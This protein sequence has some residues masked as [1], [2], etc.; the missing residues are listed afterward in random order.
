VSEA[1]QTP[2][3]LRA[4]GL[5]LGFALGAVAAAPTAAAAQGTL[6]VDS[7]ADSAKLGGSGVNCRSEAAGNPCTLRAAIETVNGF[8]P[9]G[10]TI[11][12]PAAYSGA[13]AIKLTLGQLDLTRS[14][15]IESTGGPGS[16]TLEAQGASRVMQVAQGASVTL[17]GL[18]IGHGNP[19]G[20]GGG[21]RNL[22]SL[23]LDGVL[24][25][26][27]QVSGFRGGG[28][29]TT[30][31]LTMKGG[32]VSGNQALASPGGGLGGG[33]YVFDGGSLTAAGTSFT[34]NTAGAVGGGIRDRGAADLDGVT[35]SGNSA[36]AGGGIAVRGPGSLQLKK[37]TVSRNA[38]A[39]A[40]RTGGGGGLLAEAGTNLTMIDGLLAG[41]SVGSGVGG[42]MLVLDGT[43]ALTNDTFS[44]NSA[45]VGGA[46]AQG[47]AA[48]APGTASSAPEQTMQD[49]IKGIGSLTAS[50]NAAVVG[51]KEKV[52]TAPASPAP[53]EAV[54]LQSST[55]A[56]N[57]ANFA[58]GL[59]NQLGRML[60]VHSSIVAGNAAPGGS[61][62][63]S[64]ALTS[65]GYNV[66]N[67]D[68]C[69][70]TATGD[71]QGTNPM[72]GALGSNGGPTQT[73]AIF[74]A[75]P[76]IDSGDPACPPTAGDQRGVSRPQG[77]RCDI[78]AF[79]AVLTTPAA[80]AAVPEPPRAGRPT[81]AP[82]PA[83]AG[84]L[85]L[86]WGAVTLAARW[87]RRKERAQRTG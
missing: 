83:P 59:F 38:S 63:C 54:T 72:L 52:R 41:N 1:T 19:R 56:G 14:Q 40:S 80:L 30:G 49:A 74:A 5:A 67:A 77:A 23:A 45:P 50:E 51:T 76:A 79:E 4:L 71:M 20:D 24:V 81:P 9:A 12:V 11:D 22:G 82:N 37:S 68:D 61:P 8:L 39:G 34:G 21:I 36:A 29:Y 3:F 18:T 70:F 69:G 57:S 25:R 2:L 17:S 65:L 44:D 26:D 16:A 62:N 31:S 42:G 13:Q 84:A 15:G 47:G 55:A 58:G 48:P 85:I 7:N 75:S 10:S 86:I 64:S 66:E 73:L 28:V 27:N 78:G 60:T 43:A 35:V 32:A 33:V 87:R 53:P 46:I 6:N